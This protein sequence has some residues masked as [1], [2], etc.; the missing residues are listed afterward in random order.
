MTYQCKMVL[1]YKR[2]SL[3][4]LAAGIY[5]SLWVNNYLL[6]KQFC[7]KRVGA[8]GYGTSHQSTAVCPPSPSQL[9]LICIP[10]GTPK[11]VSTN[12]WKWSTMRLLF[13]PRWYVHQARTYIQAL[14][15]RPTLQWLQSQH[16]CLA[17]NNYVGAFTV[18][19][20]FCSMCSN[21]FH[22]FSQS[23]PLCEKLW[24]MLTVDCQ[25]KKRVATMCYYP[26]TS[27]IAKPYARQNYHE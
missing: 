11:V 16:N 9:P 15:T 13:Q 14:T 5:A 18:L 25:I 7:R 21:I 4:T 22:S 23:D 24:N 12:L 27:S 1:E 26:M 19:G 3:E 17:T 2:L 8:G 10:K 6:P 20:N